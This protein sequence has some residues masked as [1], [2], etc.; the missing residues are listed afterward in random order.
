MGRPAA[1]LRQAMAATTERRIKDAGIK[2]GDPGLLTVRDWNTALKVGAGGG[3]HTQPGPSRAAATRQAEIHN[4]GR[5]VTTDND[6]ADPVTA[7]IPGQRI[8][9][10]AVP[11]P[12]RRPSPRRP[13]PG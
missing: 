6:G 2:P 10:G 13:P 9:R 7:L 8:R 12:Q 11:K 5:T 3:G 4:G 1:R